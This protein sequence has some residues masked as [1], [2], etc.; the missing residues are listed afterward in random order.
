MLAGELPDP[1]AGGRRTFV[2]DFLA[3]SRCSLVLDGPVTTIDV[4][5]G[6]LQQDGTT[7][8]EDSE[9]SAAQAAAASAA[10]AAS[11]NATTV[12][13]CEAPGALSVLFYW[14]PV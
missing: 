3:D 10:T 5:K 8:T 2:V 6:V 13:D 7:N 14:R 9:R 1:A 11:G 4:E 12:L